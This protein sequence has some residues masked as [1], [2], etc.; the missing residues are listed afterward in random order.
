MKQYRILVINPGSTTTKIAVFDNLVPFFT[1]EIVHKSS[2][3]DCY[4]RIADQFMMREEAIINT[5]REE[6]VDIHTI[7]AIVGRGGLIH[8]VESGVYEVN[9]AMKKD[10]RNSPLGEHASNLGGLIASDLAAGLIGVRA[11][12]ADPVVVDEMEPVARLTGHPN[13]ERRSIFHALNHKAVGRLYAKSIDRK[14][15][16]INLIIIHLGGGTS[17]AAHHLGRVVD[18]TNALDG[19]GPFSPERSGTLPIGDLVRMCFSG[20][21]T[22]SEIKRMIKG[23]GGLV[24]H[25]GSNGMLDAL[26]RSNAGDAHAQLVI[27]AYV[28]NVAKYV[29]AMA[30]V[31][32]GGVDAI[33]ITGGIARSEFICSSIESSVGFIAPVVIYPGENEMASLAENGMMVLSSEIEPRVYEGLGPV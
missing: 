15:E 10:L 2:E 18:T 13:F 6:G 16:D 24:A 14:Y 19:E 31:L 1:R 23:E 30:T 33:I 28:Y 26:A 27:D 29:G 12:V 25:L 8:P 20:K 17:V 32:K 11:F 4:P 5:L 9:E 3:L 22:Q 7:S 21:Y